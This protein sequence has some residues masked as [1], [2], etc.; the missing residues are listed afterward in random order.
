MPLII[1]GMRQACLVV[2]AL[3]AL[4]F[5]FTSLHWLLVGD[6]S[7]MHYVVFLTGR[8][9]V[10]Y[11]DIVDINMPGTYVVEWIVMHVFGAGSLAWR[12]FD[13]ASGLG[14]GA[15]M[16]AIAW[17]EDGYAGP[18]AGA[19]FLLIHGRDGMNELGQRDL[20][21]AFLLLTSAAL[22]L[23]SLRRSR[24]SLLATASAVAGFATIVKPTAAVFW[25][26]MLA[27][28]LLR[29]R[30]DRSALQIGASGILP[31][32]LAPALALA[33]LIDRGAWSGFWKI[34]T[35]LVP[36]HNRLLRQPPAYF[37]L[38]PFP[39]TLVLILLIWTSA[40]VLRYRE[41]PHLFSDSEIL[42]LL[43]VLCGLFSFYIQRK[44]L[45][46][47]RYPADAFFILLA[48]L[49]FC[50]ALRHSRSSTTLK[51]TAA[52]GLLVG[53]AIIAPQ[54]LLRTFKMSASPD[55]FSSLLQRDL[56]SLGG[57]ALNKKVQC[58]DFTAGCIT[59]LY[60]MRLEQSTGFL[61]DCYMFQPDNDPVVRQYRDDFWAELTTGRPNVLVLTDHD[62]G[63][64]D[65]FRKIDRWPALASL[66]QD[67]YVLYKEVHPPAPIRWA[68]RVVP[69]YS[70]RV[71]L[72]RNKATSAE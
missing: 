72:R 43:G 1:R 38:H 63:H 42:L 50:K 17:P 52:T 16:T 56:T 9:W 8:G 48:C 66:I 65:S 40:T 2:A 71:Y 28:C 58:I 36:L 67:R 39:S 19:I 68:S 32:F 24:L 14:I 4:I 25:V 33:Y 3:C 30:M 47:H 41:H 10:P 59:T 18:I 69:P 11:K 45:P 51:I 22:L 29:R 23:S 7:L 64:P 20:V 37:L 54:C 31:F 26:A 35:G 34:V 6:A 21:M 15:A 61:Y 44:A 12:L 60:R 55:D 13:L 62:C 57:A 5:S 46:Y 27:G 70:Y 53:G 49:G